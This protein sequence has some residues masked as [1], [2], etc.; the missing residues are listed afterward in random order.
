MR[1]ACIGPWRLAVIQKPE[2][3][4]AASPSLA[5]GAT[6]ILHHQLG[7]L[8][9]QAVVESITDCAICLLDRRGTVATWNAGAEL[10]TGYHADEVI[11]RHFSCLYPAEAVEADRP[12]RGLDEVASSPRFEEEGWRVRK[13]GLRFWAHVTIAAV[14]DPAVQLCGFIKIMRDIT[15]RKR[16]AELTASTHRLH[17]FIATLG[18]ELRNHL[19]PL[20]YSVG[21]L[22]TAPDLAPDVA[23]C[24]DAID[25]Q[26]GQFARLADDLLDLGRIAAG[27]VKLDIRVV[28]AGDIV[29]RAVESVQAKTN[30]RGQHID[31]ALPAGEINLRGD[32][33]RLVQVLHHLLDN[34]SKFAPRG[35]QI[36]VA[37]LAEGGTI[38][39]RVTD[40][41]PGIAPSALVSI[42]DLFD[43]QGAVSAPP[44][45]RLGLGLAL[46]R[47]FVRLHGGSIFAESP[48]RG[49][50][51]TFVARLP[52]TSEAI[53]RAAPL[54]GDT[55]T[56]LMPLRIVVVDDD[57]DTAN[58]LSVLLQ[59]EGHAPRVAYDAYDALRLARTYRPHLMLIDLSMPHVDGFELLRR[60]RSAEG[61]AGT[62]FVAVS[63]YIRPADHERT[64]HA[65]FDAHLTKRVEMH[66]LEEVL[67]RA[68]K[69]PHR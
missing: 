28:T 50:G 7:E 18:H 15:E 29:T 62:H 55:D 4:P 44:P 27:K 32:R 22:Q 69:V 41:G 8:R 65:G 5:A 63:G 2:S 47:S 46:C 19:A 16:L 37:A 42:F 38:E 20:R 54:R 57:H 36:D 53:S 26:L 67:L 1:S 17:L 3:T 60:L 25:R 45:V 68:G 43:Q 23:Q 48:G 21:I 31:V 30:A 49:Q 9:F 34:A 58:T 39:I 33:A 13:D 40:R 35:S 64:Q 61:F 51:A 10:T 56:V 52:T 66:A 6:A 59:A 24:R 12:M 14:R 11:G